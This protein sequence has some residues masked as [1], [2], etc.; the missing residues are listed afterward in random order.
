MQMLLSED[1]VLCPKIID[2]AVKKKG[3]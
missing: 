2:L 3:D 1:E